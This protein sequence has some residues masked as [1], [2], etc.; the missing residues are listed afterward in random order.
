[1]L[2]AE[3]W[4]LFPELTGTPVASLMRDVMLSRRA[5]EIR[6]PSPR[7]RGQDVIARVVP[8][9]DTGIRIAFRFATAERR[10]LRRQM[11]TAVGYMLVRMA[12]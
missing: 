2:G 1:M 5:G 6:T 12:A 7:M 10:L 3:C 11:M 4:R 9:G 8:D